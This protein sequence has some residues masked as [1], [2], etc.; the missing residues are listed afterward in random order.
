MKT[1]RI[2]KDF[3]ADTF[4]SLRAW[5]DYV[6]TEKGNPSFFI[7]KETV[8][9][10]NNGLDNDAFCDYPQER[11]DRYRVAYQSLLDTGATLFYFK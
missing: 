4:K 5:A 9:L 1:Y 3:P 11:R 7:A 8:K 6:S 2:P 10:L